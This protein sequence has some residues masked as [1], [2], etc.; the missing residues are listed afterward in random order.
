MC[1]DCVVAAGSGEKRDAGWAG[2]GRGRRT[3]NVG[4]LGAEQQLH[5]LLVRP[6][7]QHR[8][9]LRR[10]RLRP[11]PL[12]RTPTS[13]PVPAVLAPRRPQPEPRLGRGAVV[14][15]DAAEWEMVLRGGVGSQPERCTCCL[16]AQPPRHRSVAACTALGAR[17]H[18][19]DRLACPVRCPGAC[20]GE[21]RVQDSPTRVSKRQRAVSLVSTPGLRGPCVWSRTEPGGRGG[22][23]RRCRPT[24]TASWRPSPPPPP[25]SGPPARPPLTPPQQEST[26]ARAPSDRWGRAQG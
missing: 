9:E 4:G 26:A 7:S 3:Q 16:T 2:A 17:R 1:S 20:P 25:S 13:R 6:L 8:Q 11:A 14:R 24:G 10:H 19:A 23:R 5:A 15:V 18:A 12:M 21:A 22:S